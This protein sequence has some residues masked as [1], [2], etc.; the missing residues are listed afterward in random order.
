MR[1]RNGFSL[2]ELVIAMGLASLISVVCYQVMNES[3]SL[4]KKV[5][6]ALGITT[7]RQTIFE[8]LRNATAIANT[9]A[10]PTNAA[11]FACVNSG[12]DCTGAGGQINLY[13]AGN[14]LVR[15]VARTGA[16]TDGFTANGQ[17]CNAFTAAGNDECP[18]QYVVSWAPRCPAGACVN[19]LVK[20]AA[21]L[22]FKPVSTA[23]FPT[24]NVN[25]FNL[26]ISRPNKKA[27]FAEACAKVG[28]TVI[29]P[30]RCKL[31]YVNNACPPQSWVTGFDSNSLPICEPI[32]GHSCPQ[33]Q[34]LIGLDATG[35]AYCG[36]GCR[37]LSSSSGM[38]W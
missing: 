29:P 20:F 31:G 10:H 35:R 26:N 18:Y 34:V 11:V 38:I 3:F 8:N 28:G 17:I 7:I 6:G 19:P 12:T 23:K 4:E 32:V 2:V 24:M 16:A 5:S 9:I 37:S 1:N 25:Q 22:D 21:N 27:S 13:D 15:G 33:G 30:N 36:P 14:N